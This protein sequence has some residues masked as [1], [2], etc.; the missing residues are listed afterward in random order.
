MESKQGEKKR[1]KPH[2]VRDTGRMELTAEKKKFSLK[3]IETLSLQLGHSLFV[4]CI[5]RQG[6]SSTPPLVD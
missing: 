4:A 3:A 1:K 2:G 5:R 6:S